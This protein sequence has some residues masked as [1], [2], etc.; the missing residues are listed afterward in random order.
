[1]YE[2]ILTWAKR[3]HN[4]LSFLRQFEMDNVPI[5]IERTF[6]TFEEVEEAVNLLESNHYHPLRHFNS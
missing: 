4:H 5:A 2:G 3:V 1:M 6:E